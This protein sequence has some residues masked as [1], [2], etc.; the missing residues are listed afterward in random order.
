MKKSHATSTS[1][2]KD[3]CC[4]LQ[5]FHA[6]TS[7]DAAT[8]YIQEELIKSMIY[9]LSDLKQKLQRKDTNLLG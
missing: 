3:H 1:M 6:S 7:Q 5:L 2:K 9:L 8:F 4:P